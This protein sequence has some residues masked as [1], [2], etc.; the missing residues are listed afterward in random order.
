VSAR[1]KHDGVC[2]NMGAFLQHIWVV[3]PAQH[4]AHSADG[5]WCKSGGQLTVH[6]EIGKVK[7]IVRLAFTFA[8]GE[9]LYVSACQAVTVS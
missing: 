8:L 4:P 2:L 9:V 1:D 7:S 3:M 6:I 5:G